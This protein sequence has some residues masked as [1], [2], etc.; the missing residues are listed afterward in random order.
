MQ[1]LPHD[2]QFEAV[3][4]CGSQP[5]AAVQSENPV[6]HAP[7]VHVPVLHDAAAFRKLHGTSQSPQLVSVRT[8]RSQP[9]S[10]MSSQLF[11]PALHVGE[12]PVVGLQAVVPLSLVHTSLH[13]RQ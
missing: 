12:Q 8:S 1:A 9:L 10:A 13:E 6:L 5:D 4:S 2:A 11:Q 3:P 7:I